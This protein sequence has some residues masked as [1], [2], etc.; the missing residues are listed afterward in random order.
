MTEKLKLKNCPF[1]GGKAFATRTSVNDF[2]DRPKCYWVVSCKDC[3]IEGQNFFYT[4]DDFDSKPH[5]KEQYLECK[6]KAIEAWNK[7]A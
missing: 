4:H 1:C 7:R 5:N 2:D 3:N 6:Q